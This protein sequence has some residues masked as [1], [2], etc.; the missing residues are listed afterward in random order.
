MSSLPIC[1]IK[2]E[3][4]LPSS[5]QHGVPP[6]PY[7]P[8]AF[9]LGC[10]A[11][12]VHEGWQPERLLEACSG[13]GSRRAQRAAGKQKQKRIV[14]DAVCTKR[15][16]QL[17]RVHGKRSRCRCTC[18]THQCHTTT[19]QIHQVPRSFVCCYGHISLS[20]GVADLLMQQPINTGQAWLRTA[21]FM[22][23]SLLLWSW[24]ASGV[25]CMFCSC[26]F[27]RFANMLAGACAII[28]PHAWVILSLDISKCTG[29]AASPAPI[30]IPCICF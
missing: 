25:L 13:E 1:A 15:I 11:A 8:A 29:G 6:A 3:A 2:S 22:V 27:S 24:N 7:A 16:S 20:C 4:P 30:Y 9:W 12:F 28:V 26:V 23:G 19:M 17:S 14:V 10:F 5:A 18:A 21:V